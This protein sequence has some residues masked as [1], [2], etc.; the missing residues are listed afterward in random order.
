MMTRST[1]P[2]VT[3]G[4]EGASASASRAKRRTHFATALLLA[5]FIAALDTLM[6][7]S[8][9]IGPPVNHAFIL[10]WLGYDLI[11]CPLFAVSLFFAALAA[12]RATAGGVR[13]TIAWGTAV[14]V[15]CAF[16]SALQWLVLDRLFD[17][18]VFVPG[19]VLPTQ[20]ND[21]FPL[22]V[23]AWTRQEPVWVFLNW[24]IPAALVTLLYARWRRA[25][26]V[27]DRVHAAEIR[28]SQLEGQM[29]EARLQATSARIDPRF[30]F[31]TLGRVKAL[32]SSDPRR[33]IG[34][35]DALI[36]YLRAASAA[37]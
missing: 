36:G 18:S 1:L 22:S 37:Q 19:Q 12:E 6:N 30:L 14:L 2:T 15:G 5:L 11:I 10:E 26:D 33:A 7:F 35:L 13:Y 29:L 28:R 23:A 8:N 3:W 9:W 20:A 25:V 31:D 27:R 16:A 21:M 34:E 4:P 17:W 32:H 24:S